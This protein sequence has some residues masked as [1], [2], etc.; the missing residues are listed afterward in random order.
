MDTDTGIEITI[1]G[2][3]KTHETF[4]IGFDKEDN[5]VFFKSYDYVKQKKVA[6]A[7]S[8]WVQ[9]NCAYW[10]FGAASEF[11]I[12]HEDKRHNII[13]PW[14]RDMQ[15]EKFVLF[16][17]ES[18]LPLAGKGLT[19]NAK[20]WKRIYG[21]IVGEVPGAKWIKSTEKNKHEKS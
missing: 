6:Q 13:I 18:E 11:K 15:N 7:D 2:Q 5:V 21:Y 16:T 1:P 8:K 9:K 4:L 19:Y 12:T 3:P 10:E 20:E 14:P 17:M